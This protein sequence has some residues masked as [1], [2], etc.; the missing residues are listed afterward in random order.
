MLTEKNWNVFAR[1]KFA[2]TELLHRLSILL[3]EEPHI[4][5]I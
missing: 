4:L 2:V 5:I 3:P 1:H